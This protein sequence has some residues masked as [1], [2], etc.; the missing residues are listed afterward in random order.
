MKINVYGD[1][2]LDIKVNDAD[3]INE[4][5]N[6]TVRL[7][8]LGSTSGYCVGSEIIFR[9]EDECE[10]I[11]FKEALETILESIGGVHDEN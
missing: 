1:D 3:Y 7:K 2:I 5:S 10:I 11:D 6:L 9:F 4:I 8:P